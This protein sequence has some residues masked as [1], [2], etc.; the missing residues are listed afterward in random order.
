MRTDDWVHKQTDRQ[1][2]GIDNRMEIATK[3][4][5][6]ANFLGN[7]LLSVCL[8]LHGQGFDNFLLKRSQK[9]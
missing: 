6:S 3:R 8:G 2:D 4:F 1:E 9:R 5:I 7:P